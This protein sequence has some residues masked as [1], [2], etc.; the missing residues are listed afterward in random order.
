MD[1]GLDVWQ[2]ERAQERC[3][4]KTKVWL[5]LATAALLM[6][7]G[8]NP[9]DQPRL[10]LLGGMAAQAG[11]RVDFSFFYNE[12]GPYGDWR[13]FEPY[14]WVWYPDV[15]R[16]WR[17]YTVGNWVFTDDYGWTWVSAD[18]WGSIPF[19]Y[20]RWF[21]DRDHGGWAWVPGTEWGP[22][23]VGWRGG[24][25]FIGWAPLP[26]EVEFDPRIGLVPSDRNF[27]VSWNTW[28]FVPSHRFLSRRIERAIVPRPRNAVLLDR[29][30]N[31]THYTAAGRRVVNRS[32]DP[33]RF[34]AETRTRVIRYRVDETDRPIVKGRAVRDG[35]VILFQP[36]VVKTTA[37][38]PRRTD[39]PRREGVRPGDRFERRYP[40]DAPRRQPAD[41]GSDR[42]NG[43]QRPDADYFP[44][45]E[46][47]SVELDG[48][49]Q[50][51]PG[52]ERRSAEGRNPDIERENKRLAEK[53]KA[54]RQ[55]ELEQARQ[56]QVEQEKAQRQA[57]REQARQQQQL[58]QEKT[59]Q[60]AE[61]ERAQ[62]Q[63]E[64]ERAR[65]QAIQQ[66]QQQQQLEQ[67]KARQRAEQEQARRQ[68]AEQAQAQQR[69]EQE[70]TRQQAIQQ[71]QQQ[72]Q[73]QQ[74][75]QERAQRQAEREARQQEQAQQQ[76]ERE[77]RQQERAQRQAEREARQQANP[78]QQQVLPECKSLPP[79]QQQNCR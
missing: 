33:G 32:I 12:L 21:Y 51:A 46:P 2:H 58:E 28:C 49:D 43:E 38:P 74:T 40:D 73:Q 17:P 53:E 59:R 70:R 72:Q 75:E 24:D 48:R 1:D 29:T 56:R 78:Q 22:A 7:A 65:Q 47:R 39:R 41:A 45:A 55:A 23:W 16:G 42:R 3:R 76:A 62:K 27:G 67:E 77:A 6:N 63:A 52:I 4:M 69:A 26:P 30:V 66:Q 71:Q 19:H 31:I 54:Q 61:Q 35:R 64:Q 50:Q 34:E 79:G 9:A 14:G 44:R 8:L 36:E 5:A 15:G 68:Q 25:G 20:G 37:E 11:V 60:R 13:R 10:T 57:E 18:P